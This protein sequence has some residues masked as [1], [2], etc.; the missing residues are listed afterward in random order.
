MFPIKTILMDHK[1]VHYERK[2]LFIMQNRLFEI[3]FFLESRELHMFRSRLGNAIMQ[4]HEIQRIK[5]SK[6][7]F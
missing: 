5:N 7:V 6:N 1:D 2:E 3:A 4:L